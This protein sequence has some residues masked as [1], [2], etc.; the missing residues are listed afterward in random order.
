MK[1][2]RKPTASESAGVQPSRGAPPGNP[3]RDRR[4]KG[5]AQGSAE[6]PPHVTENAEDA[7]LQEH[8]PAPDD[9]PVLGPNAQGRDKVPADEAAQPIDEESMYDGRPSEDKDR[10]PSAPD[11]P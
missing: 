9:A 3:Q 2:D 7:P 8:H 1:P 5:T 10:P 6:H 4:E 11:T